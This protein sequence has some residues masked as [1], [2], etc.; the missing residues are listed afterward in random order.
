MSYE[1]Q[2]QLKQD[3]QFIGRCQAVAIEQSAIF[4]NDQR[5]DFVALAEAIQRGDIAL[6]DT[7]V[8][9]DAAG[10][11]V[12]D[13]VDQGDGTID[14]SQVTDEDLLSLTQAN[15]PDIADLYFNPEGDRIW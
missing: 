3:I 8:R 5:A 9:L 12:A 7:F 2:N 11:G 14:Q 10:P 15:W 6:L 1:T 13:K 4:K